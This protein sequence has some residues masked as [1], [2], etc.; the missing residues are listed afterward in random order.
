MLFRHTYALDFLFTGHH[1]NGEEGNPFPITKWIAE[2]EDHFSASVE[3]RRI[4]GDQLITALS[5]FPSQL[6]PELLTLEFVEA[7]DDAYSQY[8]APVISYFG[9][10]DPNSLKAWQQAF[11]KYSRHLQ[12]ALTPIL[13]SKLRELRA[14]ALELQKIKNLDEVA[15]EGNHENPDIQYFLEHYWIYSNF[16]RKLQ[17]I[18]N[19]AFGFSDFLVQQQELVN[20][21]KETI[22]VTPTLCPQPILSLAW[23]SDIGRVS[24]KSASGKKE[25]IVFLEEDGF[26]AVSIYLNLN[27]LS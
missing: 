14:H 3:S 4:M 11:I 1:C 27:S 9:L 21:K 16:G 6:H 10:V 18:L 19:N 15:S 23:L 8:L 2:T 12:N 7:F 13:E 5:Q 20:T 26:K 25:K 24:K 17:L 22:T